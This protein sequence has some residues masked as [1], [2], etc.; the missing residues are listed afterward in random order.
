MK[1]IVK[2]INYKGDNYFLCV[3]A[4]EIVPPVMAPTDAIAVVPAAI[5]PP[6]AAIAPPPIAAKEALVNACPDKVLMTVPVVAVDPKTPKLP[7]LAAIEGAA[8]KAIP[9]EAIVVEATIADLT[10]F[11]VIYSNEFSAKSRTLEIPSPIKS[12]KLITTP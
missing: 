2:E 1:Q 9:P 5:P 7:M 4:V 6:P 8:A 3:I 10:G 12:K 11:S